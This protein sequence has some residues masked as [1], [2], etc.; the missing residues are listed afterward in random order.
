MTELAVNPSLIVNAEASPRPQV[1]IKALTGVRAVAAA[2]VVVGH[3]GYVAKTLFPNTWALEPFFASCYLGVDLFF[4]LSGFILTHNYLSDFGRVTPGNYG[5]FLWARLARLYPVHIFTLMM[6]VFGVALGNYLDMS[7]NAPDRLTM[8]DFF[9]HLLLT[10]AWGMGRP[11][12]WNGPAWSI[13]AE[14]FAYLLFPFI[15]VALTRVNSPRV[16]WAGVFVAYLFLYAFLGSEGPAFAP[17]LGY[18][19]PLVRVT[20][21][22][23]AGCFLYRVYQSGWGEHFR[24]SWIAT[25]CV[26]ALLIYMFSHPPQHDLSVVP[27]PILAL[28]ILA[29]ARSQTGIAAI[30]ATPIFVFWGEVSY[31]L[32]MTHGVLAMVLG[33]VLH[34]ER[35]EHASVVMKIN[36]LGAYVVLISVLAIATYLLVE[37]PSR[38]WMRKLFS[39]R[40]N[41][42]ERPDNPS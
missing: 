40:P 16:A 23:I 15:A 31:A 21:Q 18:D 36:V 30:L 1:V 37:K 28:F 2:W 32:Y 41:R 5:R 9:H 10:H 34:A 19:R 22:F 42:V 11:D 13:S 17:P 35:F 14:W 4:V 6:L 38:N 24:W 12:A 27:A 3:F 25:G 7:F 26:I 20:T 8:S 29:L 33:K 39:N